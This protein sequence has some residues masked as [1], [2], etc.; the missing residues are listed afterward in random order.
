MSLDNDNKTL[1][2]D[3][4]VS[5]NSSH[6]LSRILI[7]TTVTGTKPVDVKRKISF[8]KIA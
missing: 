3:L 2:T 6:P 1:N 7:P 4:S 8:Y 5:E